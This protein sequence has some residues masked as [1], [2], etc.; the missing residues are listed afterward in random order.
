MDLGRLPFATCSAKPTA[1]HREGRLET[2][3]CRTP[4]VLYLRILLWIT[5]SVCEALVNMLSPGRQRLMASR[6]HRSHGSRCGTSAAGC[7]SL[8]RARCDGRGSEGGSLADLATSIYLLSW[9]ELGTPHG[10]HPV[11]KGCSKPSS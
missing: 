4:A 3:I 1:T 11:Q 10:A 6:W 2:G 7:A 8:C 5:F 9:Q